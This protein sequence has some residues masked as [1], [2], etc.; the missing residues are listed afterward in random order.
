M[1]TGATGTP[2]ADADFDEAWPTTMGA[3]VTVGVVDSGIEASHPDLAGQTEPGTS[4]VGSSY[5]A[6]TDAGGHGTHVAG[7]IAA[8][9]NAIGVSGGAPQAK[10]ESLRVFG[11]AG[12]T[13]SSATV[14]AAFAA[15]GDAGLRS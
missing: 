14:A 12:S 7:I 1:N 15:A 8:A 6:E 10:V 9:Q 3:G 4:F 5:P 11:A 13:T 2:D